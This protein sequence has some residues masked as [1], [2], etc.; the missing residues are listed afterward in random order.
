MDTDAPRRSFLSW[1]TGGLMA[2]VGAA[3]AVPAGWLLSHPIRR[4]TVHGG[5]APIP[6]ARL[7]A[8]PEGVPVRATVVAPARFDAWSRQD[9]VPLGA[10]WLVRKGSEVTALSTTCPHAGCFVDW[11]PKNTRFQCPCH[12]S[13][14]S[15]DG[16]RVAGPSPRA[17]DSL[18]VEVK[19]GKVLVQYRRFR[20]AVSDKE[21]LG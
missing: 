20:Q 11:E 21:T 12:E 7:D 8:L 4:K 14:F 2:A 9:R 18:T 16:A 17:M 1:I 13:A 10:V 5:E 3:L 19:D 15:L 6:V